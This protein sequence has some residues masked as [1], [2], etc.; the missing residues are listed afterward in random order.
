MSYKDKVLGCIKARVYS[1]GV[2]PSRDFITIE[3]G[4]DREQVRSAMSNLSRRGDIKC[5]NGVWSLVEKDD[6]GALN[7]IRSI[8]NGPLVRQIG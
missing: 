8:I 7:R 6:G 1:R 5:K 4:L 2:F 3:T